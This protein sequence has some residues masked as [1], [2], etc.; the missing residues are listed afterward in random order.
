MSLRDYDSKLQVLPTSSLYVRSSTPLSHIVKQPFAATAFSLTIG[1]TMTGQQFNSL[2]KSVCKGG[3]QW[4]MGRG[5]NF[6]CGLCLT[7]GHTFAY[8][9]AMNGFVEDGPANI[10]ENTVF[11]SC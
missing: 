3:N 6:V 5:R 7:V 9:A 4:K 2:P 10:G 11:F 8:C 1:S